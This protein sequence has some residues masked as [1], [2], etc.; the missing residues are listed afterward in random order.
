MFIPMWLL[1]I[2]VIFLFPDIIGIVLGLP[3]LIIM[4]IFNVFTWLFSSLLG[5]VFVILTITYIV[6]S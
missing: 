3:Y 1:V 4:L 2:I 6:L 5:I